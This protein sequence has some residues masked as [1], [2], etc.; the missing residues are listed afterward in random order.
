MQSTPRSSKTVF[1]HPCINPAGCLLLTFL[2][3]GISPS[4][5]A[6]ETIQRSSMTHPDPLPVLEPA[7]AIGKLDAAALVVRETYGPEGLAASELFKATDHPD[8]RS[9]VEISGNELK[10][11]S[12]SDPGKF[13]VVA[14][15]PPIVYPLTIDLT[16]R[17]EIAEGGWV[18]L[19]AL[20]NGRLASPEFRSQQLRD[21][22]S[23]E[24]V[25][26]DPLDSRT[27]RFV[28]DSEGRGRIYLLD[29]SGLSLPVGCKDAP[30]VPVERTSL[31][32]RLK[33]ANVFIQEVCLYLGLP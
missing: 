31:D 8:F 2:L 10:L 16:M 25:S 4:L 28:F 14:L 24:S 12:E 7:R 21:R 23:N 15:A 32:I 18:M 11:S 20:T 29:G 27:Y 30:K 26:L 9:L 13:A 33:N 3:I 22:I 1:R 5:P 6:Q 17:M 19:Q